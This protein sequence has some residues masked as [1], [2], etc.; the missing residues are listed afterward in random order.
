MA[1]LC[2]PSADAGLAPLRTSRLWSDENRSG[3]GRLGSEVRRADLSRTEDAPCSAEMTWTNWWP[4]TRGRRFRFISRRMLP[5][6]EIRQ[7]PI[8]LKTCCLLRRNGSLP[9]GVKAAR[10]ARVDTLFL[11]G[12]HHLWGWFDE[13]G[14][15]VTALGR[16]ADGD[17]DS[18]DF[19]AL[20]TL[21]QG[22]SVMLVA[23][24]ALPP[25][26]LSAAILRYSTIV[27]AEPAACESGANSAR[28]RYYDKRCGPPL[29]P[30]PRSARRMRSR[31]RSQP[32]RRAP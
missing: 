4:W 23:R 32:V 5:G 15:C 18:L 17:I 20:L 21:R 29:G 10:Y 11:A 16:A 30:W 22:G 19:A 24:E 12:D 2:R 9:H 13:S 26:G 1:I 25:P 6:R 31:R 7:D 8:R 27:T 28:S 14:D 3:N